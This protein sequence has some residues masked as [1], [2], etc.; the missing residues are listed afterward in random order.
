MHTGNL[1][2]TN[3]KTNEILWFLS[4]SSFFMLMLFFFL[5]TPSRVIYN[6]YVTGSL[7]QYI[8]LFTYLLF[9]LFVVVF[10]SLGCFLYVFFFLNIFDFFFLL[11]WRAKNMCITTAKYIN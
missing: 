5:F 1:K 9:I 7:K 6:L 2:L 3:S 10:F 8:Y 4:L 11:F